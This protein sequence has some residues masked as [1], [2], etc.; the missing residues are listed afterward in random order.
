MSEAN[1][2][3]QQP[4]QSQSADPDLLEYND[5]FAELADEIVF[6]DDPVGDMLPAAEALPD[7]MIDRPVTKASAPAAQIPPAAPATPAPTSSASTSVDEPPAE[8]PNTGEL[9]H[10]IQE[11]NQCNSI[12]LDRVSQLED[13]LEQAQKQSAVGLSG[14]AETAEDLLAT[15][16]QLAEMV[17][18]I[19]LAQQT[20]QR[21]QILIETLTAQLESSQERIG[22]LEREAALLQQR[23]NEQA[24]VITQ[25]ENTC[26]DLQARLQRQQRYTLQ[27]KVALEKCLE[28][29]TVAAEAESEAVADSTFLPKAQNIRPWSA[30]SGFGGL[31]LPWL[32]RDEAAQDIPAAD[33]PAAAEQPIAP[34]PAQP[35]PLSLKLPSFPFLGTPAKKPDAAPKP[36]ASSTDAVSYNLKSGDA[37]PSHAADDLNPALM[38]QIDAAVQPLADLIAEAMIAGKSQSPQ[39]QSTKTSANPF[40]AVVAETMQQSQASAQ[41][42][43]LIHPE[44]DEDALW[45]DL[46]RLIDVSTEDIVKASLSGDLSAFEAIDF[47]AFQSH[48]AQSA[49]KVEH[50]VEPKPSGAAPGNSEQSSA[51][52]HTVQTNAN[53]VPALATASGWPSPVVY[54]LRPTK[55]RKSLAAVDLPTFDR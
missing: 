26:R 13:A 44:A 21:Q 24:Q 36:A 15:Q 54:P 51:H 37:S 3:F 33:E 20:T 9:I 41:S 19:D 1:I 12:L 28:M 16:Q 14:R 39:S 17:S 23:C 42:A 43:Q 2:P 29:P 50:R 35:K 45:Q 11:L 22:Q 10:L 53:T 55:K 18:Q 32:K 46:A 8:P 38:Q 6:E 27:F 31:P 52:T 40:D 49:P 4:D 25:S 7:V 47:Q 30:Q 34:P 5:I 48:E